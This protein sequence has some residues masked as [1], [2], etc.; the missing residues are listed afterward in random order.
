[1]SCMKIRP[2]KVE[3]TDTTNLTVAFAILR[4][5]TKTVNFIVFVL[6]VL[7]LSRVHLQ[8]V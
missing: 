5:A 3:W 8:R 4:T 2:V 7:D 1:M 6:R